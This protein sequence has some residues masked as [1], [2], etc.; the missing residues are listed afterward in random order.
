MEIRTVVNKEYELLKEWYHEMLS[1]H[2]DKAAVL[3]KEADNIFNNAKENTD[4]FI[5]YS[6]LNF[7]YRM[8]NGDF[9][10]EFEAF[11]YIK[12]M[13]DCLLK[14]YYHFFKFIYD[15]E[16][17]NYNNAEYHCEL[18]G[19]LLNMIPNEAEK[20][21][22]YYRVAL[23]HYYLSQPTLA[24]NYA[25]KALD[26]F[27]S[28]EDYEIKVGACKNT[29]GM[30]CVTL[31]QF[32]MAEEY[33]ISALNMFQQLNEHPLA[34]KVRSNLGVFYAEQNLSDLAIRHLTEVFKGC[35]HTK[36]H[37]QRRV[38]FLLAREHIKLNEN[39]DAT[40]YIAEGLKVCNREYK[41][42]L[43]ILKSINNNEPIEKL[44]EVVTEALSYFKEQDLWKD[45]QIYTE[46]L[47]VK[48]YNMG[49]KDKACDYYHLSHEART[50]LK[51]KGR[52]K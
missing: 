34:L 25:T 15:T 49:V 16:V 12:D 44:E 45:V 9:E 51:E 13:P 8:L 19:N 33:L 2:L 20:A 17:G 37:Y 31:E 36:E 10:K 24:I 46:L 32:D 50:L 40:F 14:Y 29:L 28:H 5:Y 11:D 7:R 47:A 26:Y 41:Y 43:N 27:S 1:Q 48:W 3:K 42:H 18:A 30:A 52:L 35:Q 23:Y 38:T 6:L 4:S 21:E 22:Y 39:K